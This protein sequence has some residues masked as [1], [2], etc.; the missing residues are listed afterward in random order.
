LVLAVDIGTSALK[1]GTFRKEGKEF[2]WERQ[3]SKEYAVN[4]Y[5]NGMFNDIE[6]TKWKEAFIAGC[7]ELEDVLP[8]VDAVALSGT[9]P[10]LTAMDKNGEA[11]YPA[12]LMFDQ[13]AKRQAGEII[14]RCGLEHILQTTANYPVPGGCSLPSILW[15][16]EEHPEIFK[17]TAVFGHSN[18]YF[19][20]WLTGEFAIDPSSA[21][22]TILYNTVKNDFTWNGDI[23]G[24]F[25]LSLSRLPQVLPSNNSIGR[26]RPEI[27][28][29]LGLV[30][31]PPVIIGGNDAALAAFANGSDTPGKVVNVNGTCEITLVCLPRCIPSR[32]YNIRAHVLP[33]LWLTNYAMNA[34]GKAIEWFRCLFCSEMKK[35]DF[36]GGFVSRSIEKWTEQESELVY[37]PYL[38]GSRYSLEKLTAGFSGLTL[39]TTREEM[40]AALIKGLYQY[41]QAHLEEISRSVSLS[42]T[43]IV[44]G[45]AVTDVLLKAKKKWMR[46]CGYIRRDHSSLEGAAR[47]G[48]DY[49]DGV[50]K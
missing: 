35:E 43:I 39:E 18:T 9:T 14:D 46:E 28:K 40:F 33:G 13:R 8:E 15:L 12:I 24:E 20:K 17:R 5:N 44:T 50:D 27:A 37:T 29:K 32:N 42:D 48:Y 38:M 1:M 22:L 16:E 41:Q 23:A 36:F 7:R 26:V 49:I 19:G 10:G 45:G 34:A 3:F 25:G 30:K 47:L 4:T 11:L 21:S 6:Q 2:L 31:E